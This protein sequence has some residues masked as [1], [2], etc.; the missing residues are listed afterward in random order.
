MLGILGFSDVVL[1]SVALINFLRLLYVGVAMGYGFRELGKALQMLKDIGVEGVIIGDTVL[2]YFLGVKELSG[3]VD[4][5]V[6]SLSPFSDADLIS[7][8]VERLGWDVGMTELGTPSVIALVEGKE[9]V[10]ELYENLFDF[11]VPKQ[12]VDGALTV[13]IGD[14]RSRMITLENYIV[15][16]ARAGRERDI[17]DLQVISSLMNEGK[18]RINVRSI[19]KCSEFFDEDDWKSIVSRLRF[20]GIKV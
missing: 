15:L 19:R 6:T 12:I 17:N 18:L 16:K 5:F 13:K 2:N 20:V 1:V 11:Y 4:L 10:I 9:I 7:A 8:R 3:D 14:F